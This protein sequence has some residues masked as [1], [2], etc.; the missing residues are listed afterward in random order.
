MFTNSSLVSLFSS[1][2]H[3][4]TMVVLYPALSFHSDC[5]LSYMGLLSQLSAK[6][7]SRFTDTDALPPNMNSPQKTNVLLMSQLC[8]L[9]SSEFPCTDY[10]LCC[11]NLLYCLR[12]SELQ[13]VFINQYTHNC[14]QSGK[15]DQDQSGIVQETTAALKF[16]VIYPYGEKK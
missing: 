12:Q 10:V 11:V 2:P 7:S 14:H 3:T 8:I 6:H 16:K 4:R 1:P 9:Y 5:V 15:W 13:N